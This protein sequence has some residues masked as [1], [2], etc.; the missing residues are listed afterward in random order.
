M[1]EE[2]WLMLKQP[3]NLCKSTEDDKMHLVSLMSDR[4]SGYHWLSGRF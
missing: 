1:S 3:Y 4:C 2:S